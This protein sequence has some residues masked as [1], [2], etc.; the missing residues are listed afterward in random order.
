MIDNIKTAH[1]IAT[2]MI[3]PRWDD[4][5][6]SPRWE[7]R[8]DRYTFTP[9][10]EK[11]KI[12]MQKLDEQ[13]AILA[14]VRAM[15]FVESKK[16][17]FENIILKRESQWKYTP[18]NIALLAV[19]TGWIWKKDDLI[20]ELKNDQGGVEIQ[21]PIDLKKGFL[22]IGN[23]GSGKTLIMESISEWSRLLGKRAFNICYAKQECDR[24][25]NEKQTQVE[26]LYY[27]GAWCI[28]EMGHEKG[29][30]NV[31][32]NSVNYIGDLIE[33]RYQ[34]NLITHATTNID[35][36]PNAAINL[37]QI[38]GGRVYSRLHEMYNVLYLN[39]KDWRKEKVIERMGKV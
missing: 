36:S 18:Q 1:D 20:Y 22:L 35:M 19:L 21:I 14:E 8:D 12:K 31:W 7:A 11:E 26:N 29:D 38:Y 13:E 16:Y 39:G 6:I 34:K 9:L 10:T 27:R 23:Y 25:R 32:G 37:N 24:A 4:E 33:H 28:D 3:S 15:T 5:K 30:A 2:E 17:L